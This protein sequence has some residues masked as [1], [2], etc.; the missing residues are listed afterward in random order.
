[1]PHATCNLKMVK[2]SKIKFYILEN[3]W[4]RETTDDITDLGH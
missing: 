3:H 4:F 1:M 2:R